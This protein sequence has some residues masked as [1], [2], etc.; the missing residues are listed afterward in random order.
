MSNAIG[1]DETTWP[2][3]CPHCGSELQ[4]HTTGFTPRATAEG[5]NNES[6]GGAVVVED[7]CPNPDCPARQENAPGSLGGD[8]GGA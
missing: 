1:D 6:V 8:N 4:S 7:F 5:Q 3:R 2:R